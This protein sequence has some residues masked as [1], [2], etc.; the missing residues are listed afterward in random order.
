MSSSHSTARSTSQVFEVWLS[1]LLLCGAIAVAPASG[2]AS[3]D[4][5][6]RFD[7]NSGVC[8][9]NVT[10]ADLRIAPCKGRSILVA[11]SRTGGAT[12]IQCSTPDAVSESL[13]YLFDR[14]AA[15]G[16]A[17][18]L[19]GARFIKPDFLEEAVET[20]IPDRFGA[21]PLCAPPKPGTAAS[22]ELLLVVRTAGP[23]VGED[24][25]YHLWRVP[26]ETAKLVIKSAEGKAPIPSRAAG[27]KWRALVRLLLPY[28]Q[29]S[30][31]VGLPA[32][33]P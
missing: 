28:V 6:A 20:G 15:G 10:A 4:Q 31:S 14:H 8:G 27:A 7:C 24:E 2:A 9:F 30:G 3:G 33:Q 25:C 11:Y 29:G 26:S 18:E 23:R 5:V 19:R 32:K 21:V 17:F 13:S 16:P 22:G 12:L 1:G